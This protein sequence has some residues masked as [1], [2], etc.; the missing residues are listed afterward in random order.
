[1]FFH[2]LIEHL[3]CLLDIPGRLSDIFLD[4]WCYLLKK[5]DYLQAQLVP[6]CLI[7]MQIG[8]VSHVRLSDIFQILLN[9]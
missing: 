7:S 8:T 3:P 6:E 1:M 4:R 9:I 2:S 5:G